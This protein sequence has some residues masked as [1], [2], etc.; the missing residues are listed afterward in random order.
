MVSESLVFCHQAA[1]ISITAPDETGPTQNGEVSAGSSDL[2][3]HLFNPET[4]S[5]SAVFSPHSH[6]GF[7]SHPI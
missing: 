2:R 5:R 1:A 7:S 6:P 4:K 3:S